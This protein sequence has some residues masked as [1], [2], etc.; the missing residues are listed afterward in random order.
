MHRLIFA[1]ALLAATSAAASANASS[2]GDAYLAKNAK[3]MGIVVMPGLQYQV[4]A[5]GPAS[6]AHPKL[7][8]EVTVDYEGKLIDGTVFD[9][10]FKRGQPAT[11]PLKMLIP[12]WESALRLM[13]PG[14]EWVVTI[15]P[16]LAYGTPS[17]HPDVIP[18]DSVLV[19]RI[20]LI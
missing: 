13:R 5:S 7:S 18:D 10:S 20:K 16:E 2:A 9:S 11:F 15:P 17:K 19:F 8:D 3:A 4:L 14:D 12:G 6:G 1:A